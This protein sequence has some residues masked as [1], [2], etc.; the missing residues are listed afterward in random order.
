MQ[1]N[2]VCVTDVYVCVCVCTRKIH[3]RLICV[4]DCD[5]CVFVCVCVCKHCGHKVELCGKKGNNW[6]SLRS[7]SP[8]R[9]V[10]A[11]HGIPS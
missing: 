3:Y 2:F 7:I 6:R 1:T 4:C 9:V 10:C 11:T 8:K 5:V